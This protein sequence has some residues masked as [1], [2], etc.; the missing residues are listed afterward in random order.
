M[1]AGV[2]F[3][4]RHV[5][6]QRH[7]LADLELPD[8]RA[9]ANDRAGG[10]VAKDARRRH[11]AVLDLLDVGRADAAHRHPD[12]QFAR[13]DARHRH[14][15]HPQIVCPAINHR[16]HGLRNRQHAAVLSHRSPGFHRQKGAPSARQDQVVIQAFA[17]VSGAL[18]PLRLAEQAMRR[19][20]QIM[21][22]LAAATV[23]V[24]WQVSRHEFV[25]FDDPAYV[26]Y[27]PVVQQG[28]TWPGVT[29][30]SGNCMG[31]RPTGIR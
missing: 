7:A 4:A 20:W 8:A 22:L 17:I 28:L 19:D 13:P 18:F 24:F 2:T 1:P 3:E 27:N 25:N 5:M 15:L 21:A 16:L 9:D 10:F 30:P 31:R 11:R 23:A 14:R 29:G 6:M 26:T 12:E